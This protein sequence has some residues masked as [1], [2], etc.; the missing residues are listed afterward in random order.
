MMARVI[1]VVILDNKEYILEYKN[2]GYGEIEKLLEYVK[3]NV[4]S[5]DST[6]IHIRK[7]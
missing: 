1:Q 3:F 5:P 4:A 2:F 6:K 7:W